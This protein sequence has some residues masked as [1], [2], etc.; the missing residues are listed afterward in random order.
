MAPSTRRSV[1]LLIC[2]FGLMFVTTAVRRFL[3]GGDVFLAF[4]FAIVGVGY[5]VGAYLFWRHASRA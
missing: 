3:L 5:L 1:I 4:V 2:V